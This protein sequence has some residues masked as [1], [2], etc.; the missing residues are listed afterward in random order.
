MMSPDSFAS[1]IVP[2]LMQIQGY[3]LFFMENRETLEKE[4]SL[5]KLVDRFEHY[6]S[7]SQ[8]FSSHERMLLQIVREKIAT[9]SQE[10]L[11]AILI[12][13][14]TQKEDESIVEQF[15]ADLNRCK[16]GNMTSVE[17]E[18]Q[19]YRSWT[20]DYIFFEI[21]D[22]HIIE[23]YDNACHPLVYAM[24]SKMT[25]SAGA[26][27]HWFR[28]LMRALQ[29]AQYYPNRYWHSFY[30]I[31]GCA[32]AVWELYRHLDK[33]TDM[34]K[35][36]GEEMRFLKLV[37][38]LVS[39]AIV[40]GEYY[41]MPQVMD[42][43]NN[44][45]TLCYDKRM[46][47]QIMFQEIGQ[48]I[49]PDIQ[50]ISD[51]YLAYRAGARSGVGHFAMQHLFN[52]KKMY[53]FGS[54]SDVGNYDNGYT[55]IEDATWLELVERG[56]KRNL[57]ICNKLYETYRQGLLD[58]STDEISIHLREIFICHHES[59]KPKYQWFPLKE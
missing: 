23:Q 12:V 54:L 38:L 33:W 19:H 41:R 44:R 42:L 3:T 11:P 15:D 37:Y 8:P 13:D 14:P 39:R 29:Y 6:R 2:I 5:K 52:S 30:G 47:V 50:Y 45:A 25:S 1:E 59:D 26:S 36:P 28:Y 16:T 32:I 56:E 40:V 20:E 43:Y 27:D 34:F 58:F 17:A 55:V 53:E 22:D 49:I 31:Y 7:K 10:K 21:K 57:E 35:K 51:T 18:K 24:L 46:L 48:H 4:K 9:Y